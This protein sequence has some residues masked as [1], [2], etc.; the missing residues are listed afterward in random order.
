[1]PGRVPSLLPPTISHP[2]SEDGG[3]QEDPRPPSPAWQLSSL[4]LWHPF[5]QPSS[6]PAVVCA[7]MLGQGPGT[8]PPALASAWI[9]LCPLE[10]PRSVHTSTTRNQCRH[11]RRSTAGPPSWCWMLSCVWVPTAHPGAQGWQRE[12]EQ[13]QIPAH[14]GGM[15][16]ESARSTRQQW[17]VA[18]HRVP[19]CHG[20]SCPGAGSFAEPILPAPLFRPPAQ[21][22]LGFC[23]APRCFLCA[24]GAV[25]DGVTALWQPPPFPALRPSRQRGS[26]HQHQRFLPTVTCWDGRKGA[27]PL[28]VLSPVQALGAALSLPRTA[29]L[30]ALG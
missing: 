29:P 7:V 25:K 12:E 18:Q 8:A 13:L 19:S 4:H 5:L 21:L 27:G 28:W 17:D 9:Q 23:G 30:P 3:S 22:A 2:P 6:I 1:M 16:L 15:E 20:W 10:D 14:G 26:H 11:R 24:G